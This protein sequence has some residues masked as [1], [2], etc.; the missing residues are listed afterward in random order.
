M[1]EPDGPFPHHE[2]GQARLG[3]GRLV[4]ILDA[5][6]T[7]RS[8]AEAAKRLGMQPSG[9]SRALG[10][11]R[12]LFEDPLLIRSGRGLVPSPK[13][14][15][16]RERVQ[17]IA[18][19][20]HALFEQGMSAQA[21]DER[22]DDRWN[23]PHPSTV[24][25]LVFHETQLAPQS[26]G[27]GKRKTKAEAVPP[28]QTP[29]QRLTKAIGIVGAS[30]KRQGQSLDIEQAEDAMAIILRGEADPVQIGAFLSLIQVRGTT[31]GELAG[32]VRVA[33]TLLKAR[34]K[35]PRALSADLDW[36]C[37]IS[38][39]D[40]KPPWFFHAARLL[41]GAGYRIVLHGSSGSSAVAGRAGVVTAA[42]D[43]PVCAT[44]G[45]VA[46]ALA[47]RRIAYVPLADMSAQLF[48]LLGLYAL[49]NS[50]TP[51]HDLV[52]LIQP[53]EAKA[54]LLGVTKPSYKEIH[55][56]AAMLLGIRRLSIIGNT[57]DV[58]QFNPFRAT[59][60]YRLVDGAPRDEFV[61]SLPE[62]PSLGRTPITSME[63][64][65]A[66]WNGTA[67]DPRAESIII[68]TA[69]A[70]LLT[71]SDDPDSTFGQAREQARALWRARHLPDRE[72]QRP[73][74]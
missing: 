2:A 52:H 28:V 34:F 24:P 13:A 59:T 46:A 9:V 48:R 21:A 61:P 32:F 50:R 17:K 39:R 8:V 49:T 62:P 5:L 20:I 65:L 45:E 4:L 27:T 29:T 31:A 11:L 10:E 3:R 25:P 71:L 56:D 33:R 14:E 19:S 44:G 72:P 16:L 37:Y 70:A 15:E 60:V 47:G 69:A 66:V 22:F 54:S 63:H 68:A 57:K 40:Q 51:A 73:R 74:R 23:V 38:P 41:A 7:T 1:L 35:A 6:L 18:A 42:L 67:S 53:V 55:R 30:G 12:I 36:P 64:W 43:I 58:A 26:S